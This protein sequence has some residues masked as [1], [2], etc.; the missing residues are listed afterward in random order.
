[1]SKIKRRFKK[2]IN[3]LK[4]VKLPQIKCPFGKKKI[5]LLST[6]LV[7]FLTLVV[8]F[9]IG[10]RQYR[11]LSDINSKMDEIG[12]QIQLG[13]HREFNLVER[14]DIVDVQEFKKECEEFSYDCLY[15][16][17]NLRAEFLGK[18]ETENF[19]D[20]DIEVLNMVSSIDFSI[21]QDSEKFDKLVGEYNTKL[22]EFPISI[23]T[24]LLSKE[25]LL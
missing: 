6:V 21:K 20:E 9:I 1:M 16:G 24:G 14:L 4:K 22:E 13:Y 15:M 7:L 3:T 5:I 10:I 19:D 17:R 11:G 2:N 23:T 8:L 18:L 12:A 25:S